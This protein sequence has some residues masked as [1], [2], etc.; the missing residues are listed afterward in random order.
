MFCTNCG[1][2][3]TDTAK[4]CNACG[5]LLVKSEPT[6]SKPSES[7]VN[8]EDYLFDINL[9]DAG[10][11]NLEVIKFLRNKMGIGLKEAKGIVDSAPIVIKLSAIR[12]EA[13]DFRQHLLAIS[14]QANLQRGEKR[15]KT[16]IPQAISPISQKSSVIITSKEELI[17][18]LRA[19]KNTLAE[20]DKRQSAV[21]SCVDSVQ[22]SFD[23]LNTAQTHS[24]E[25]EKTAERQSQKFI[26][27][28]W[29]MIAIFT[30]IGSIFPII[31]NIVMFI[32]GFILQ[33]A[34]ICKFTFKK[35]RSTIP[36]KYREK[37]IEEFSATSADVEKFNREHT[38]YLNEMTKKSELLQS[39]LRSKDYQDIL[40]YLSD[41]Y[42]S[43]SIVNWMIEALESQR[44]DS[45]K[46]VINLYEDELHKGRLEDMQ[47]QQ[48]AM[49]ARQMAA[50]V[51][52]FEVA[53]KT[54]EYARQTADESEKATNYAKQTAANTKKA[55]KSARYGNV[56]NTV[57][58]IHHWN[59]KKKR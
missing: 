55:A 45:L 3:N 8:D 27:F 59:D 23:E 9:I 44:A 53:Q 48:I 51:Q 13:E 18:K 34:F 20:A 1:E 37:H 30:I 22:K 41:K 52:Q 26:G 15:V 58:T 24:M 54:A 29:I 17:E 39:F 49:Q 10:A 47:K 4:F 40:T 32:I 16:I 42:I 46:E 28:D 11:N 31:G 2:R 12:N 6:S 50:T 38:K 19:A 5:A 14:A 56:V 43:S 57:N 25:L 36:D 7:E 21:Q 33:A 35:R